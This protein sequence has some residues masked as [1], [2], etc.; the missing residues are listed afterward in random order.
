MN[1]LTAVAGLIT[2]SVLAGNASQTLERPNK[3]N[4]RYKMFH[5]GL[6]I[7]DASYD[8]TLTATDRH[9]LL[10][11]SETVEGVTLDA[12]F[13]D[14]S[15]RDGTPLKKVFHGV[16]GQRPFSNSAVFADGSVDFTLQDVRG[17]T[18]QATLKPPA[19]AVLADASQTWFNGV[20]PKKGDTAT[21]TNF[22]VQNGKWELTTTTFVGDEETKVG[23]KTVSTHH[24]H[25]KSDGGEMEMYVDDSAD[26]VVMDQLGSLR[27]E[28]AD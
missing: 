24:L 20:T 25:V 23:A 18:R 14:L 6:Q 12:V 21:F 27:L 1:P 19:N 3:A 9:T 22:N 7:G 2:F 10:R 4:Y 15:K 16:L 8:R 11:I 28:R 26:I 17:E 13:D 5:A